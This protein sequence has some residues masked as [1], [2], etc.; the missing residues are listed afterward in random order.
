MSAVTW[1]DGHLVTTELGKVLPIKR[2]PV[3]EA[4]PCS[5][6]PAFKVAWYVADGA[7]SQKRV[8][9]LCAPHA[10][11]R[12]KT[13]PP[14]RSLDRLRDLKAG[15]VEKPEKVGPVDGTIAMWPAEAT[16]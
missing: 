4:H 2:P 15:E 14:P 6:E 11:E 3:C 8:A 16:Q 13:D 1:P 10:N 12:V 9:F 5:A 7:A